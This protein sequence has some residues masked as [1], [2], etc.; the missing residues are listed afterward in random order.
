MLGNYLKARRQEAKLSQTVVSQKCCSVRQLSRIENNQ[1][2]PSL[3]LFI[4]LIDQLDIDVVDVITV[5][6]QQVL[7]E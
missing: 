1:S 6:K 4:L 3:E 7:R 2:L 5:L